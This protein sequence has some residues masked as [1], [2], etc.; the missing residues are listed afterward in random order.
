MEQETDDF[1]ELVEC[2]NDILGFLFVV[3]LLGS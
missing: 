3:L 1:K 2:A